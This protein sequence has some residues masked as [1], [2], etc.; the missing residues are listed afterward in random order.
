MYSVS[1]EQRGLLGD[2]ATNYNHHPTKD[3]MPSLLLKEEDQYRYGMNL[4]SR[5]SNFDDFISS[6]ALN[7]GPDERNL[8]ADAGD[9]PPV[10]GRDLTC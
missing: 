6:Q 3:N 2:E 4:V 7:R 5:T 10:G 9:A 8:C 1:R